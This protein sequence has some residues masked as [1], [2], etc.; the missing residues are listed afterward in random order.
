MAGLVGLTTAL[1][2]GPDSKKLPTGSVTPI[3]SDGIPLLGSQ[4]FF[5]F[6]PD[7]VEESIQINYVDQDIPGLSHPLKQWTSNGGRTIS[8][9]LMLSR[10]ILPKTDLPG[11]VGLVV[12]PQS[13][14][15]KQWNVDI[16]V[17]VKKLKAFGYPT[18][19]E[20]DGVTFALAPPV[21]RLELGG[22]ALGRGSED[23]VYVVMTSC[24]VTYERSFENGVPRRARVRTEFA[25][26][27]Q[28]GTSITPW[29]SA[30]DFDTS[31]FEN[32]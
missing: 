20:S 18:Y 16:R 8:F 9:E 17:F 3:A 22:M 21:L 13:P 19:Q 26:V 7:S 14:E 12:N 11:L 1:L 30:T 15:N 2:Q 32:L 4:L 31:L 27:I 23:A 25:E 24:D 10:D 29:D 6:Y 5:P 28:V